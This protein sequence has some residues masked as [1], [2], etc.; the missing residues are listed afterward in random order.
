MTVK[1]VQVL[2][3]Q[4]MD[5]YRISERNMTPQ[6]AANCVALWS[7]ALKDV[8]P[9]AGFKAMLQAFT[10]CRFPVTL[11]DLMDQLRSMQTAC[12]PTAGE[13]WH[14]LLAA[15]RQAANTAYEYSFTIRT[16][17]G[18]TQGEAA[19]RRNRTRWEQLHPAAQKWLGSLSGLIHLGQMDEYALS[20]QRREFERAYKA[21][22]EQSPLNCAALLDYCARLPQADA[23]PA[24]LQAGKRQAA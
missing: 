9:Q 6:Q 12:Q 3:Q 21:H 22:Q 19:R 14:Q 18:I 4:N 16:P 8:P 10:V 24:Q 15:A 23:A 2:I 11:A 20:Y 5:M 17:E 1:E 7:A 13:A